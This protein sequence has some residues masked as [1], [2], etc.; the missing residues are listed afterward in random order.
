MK[1]LHR[2][3]LLATASGLALVPWV[4][5]T[6]AHRSATSNP[7]PRATGEASR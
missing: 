1:T 6:P 4:S 2:R 7:S 5:A 3:H